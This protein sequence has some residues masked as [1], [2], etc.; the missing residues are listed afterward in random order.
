MEGSLEATW[1]FVLRMRGPSSNDKYK[2]DQTAFAAWRFL[3]WFFKTSLMHIACYPKIED[4]RAIFPAHWIKNTYFQAVPAIL[5][6]IHLSQP[7]IILLQ[8]VLVAWIYHARIRENT[9]IVIVGDVLTKV[10][11]DVQ[12]LGEN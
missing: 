2:T 9:V 8:D 4:R 3:S 12:K 10:S 11:Y 7:V 1:P 6:V 5:I